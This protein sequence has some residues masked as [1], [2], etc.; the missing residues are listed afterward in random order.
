MGWHKASSRMQRIL[1]RTGQVKLRTPAERI[2]LLSRNNAG[3]LRE[4]QC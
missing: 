1:P 2:G 4:N 3:E